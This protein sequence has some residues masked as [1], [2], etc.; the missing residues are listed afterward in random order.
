MIKI[1]QNLQSYFCII[2]V[3]EKDHGPHIIYKCLD[4]AFNTFLKILVLFVDKI[5]WTFE[6]NDE[7]V[8]IINAIKINLEVQ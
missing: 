3:R 6:M 2:P 5:G 1:N 8:M 4:T 7:Q